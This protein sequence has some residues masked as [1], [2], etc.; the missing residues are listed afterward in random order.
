M[1][2]SHVVVVLHI[3]PVHMD[4]LIVQKSMALKNAINVKNFRVIKSRYVGKNEGI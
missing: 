1:K 2:K 3:K 4:W